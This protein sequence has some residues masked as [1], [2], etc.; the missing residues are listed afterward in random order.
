M[1]RCGTKSFGHFFRQ[2]GLKVF[3]WEES[4]KFNLGNLYFDGK[5][6]EIFKLGIFEAYDVFE[7]YPFYDP[8]FSKILANYIPQSKFVY[9]YRNEDDWYK[10]MINHTTGLTLGDL[11]KHCYLYDR[12]E[13][14][15]FLKKNLKKFNI[16]KLSLLGMKEHYIKI[17][18]R[19][20]LQILANFDGFD[21]NRFLS[22]DLDD[23]NKF[24]KIN[25][26]WKL[27]YKKISD[28]NYHPSRNKFED[29]INKHT[30]LFLEKTK[31]IKN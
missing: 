11:E 5:L 24:K 26:A 12:L 20:R 31:P 18:N 29:T 27:N 10:S 23:K 25:K 7:D 6:N 9:F 3:S 15:E 1:Q 2:N 19:H 14:L 28:I 16:K 17:F 22:F 13:E 21:E 8:Y 30:Y 4:E